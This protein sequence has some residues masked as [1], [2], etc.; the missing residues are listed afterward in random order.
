MPPL[1]THRRARRRSRRR[2][3]TVSACVLIVVALLVGGVTQIGRQ[4]GPFDATVNR[5][6]AVQ[7]TTLVNESNNASVFLRRL[8]K[9]VPGQDR[10]TLQAGLDTL[11]AQTDQEAAAAEILATPSAPGDVE[12]AFAAVLAERADG[13]R[14]LRSTFDELLGLRP[15]PL[16]G[17]PGA[18]DTILAPPTLVSPAQAT[19]RIVAAGTVLVRADR[20]YATL[21]RALAHLAGHARLPASKWITASDD[22]QSGPIATEVASVTSSATLQVTHRLV[23]RV[24]KVTPPALPSPTGA[25]TPGLSVLSPTTNVLVQ[26]V[27]SNL[28]SV[29]EPRASVQFQLTP[30]PTGTAV[31]ITRTAGLAPAGSVSLAP[32]SF[33]VRPGTNYQLTVAVVLPAGQTD[34]TGTSLTEVL[35]IAPST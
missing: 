21:R 20:S 25:A 15:L 14:S 7:A 24:V 18:E 11:T 34:A 2:L 6:F 22:W 5:S 31:T 1:S 8:M 9:D 29:A 12:G 17:S 28:G 10:R 33:K 4:S 35:Q 23:L 27:L 16:A 32:V 19:D 13:V 3:I 26:V 30:Q